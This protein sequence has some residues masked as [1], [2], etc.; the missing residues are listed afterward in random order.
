VPDAP[1]SLIVSLH[2]AHA[3]SQAQIA[4]QVAFL[5]AYGITRSSILVVP[6]FHHQGSVL[7]DK[8]FCEAVSGWQN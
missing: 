1:K 4:E 6:E 5:K 3:G 7:Q 2:D 8:G